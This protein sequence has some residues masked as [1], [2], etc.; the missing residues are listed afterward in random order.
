MSDVRCDK[1]ICRDDGGEPGDLRGDEEVLSGRMW[2]VD[3]RNE[4]IRLGGG[5]QCRERGRG[6]SWWEKRG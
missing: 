3:I 2:M 1:S 5:G 6:D 4:R